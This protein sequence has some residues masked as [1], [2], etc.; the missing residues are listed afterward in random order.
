MPIETQK[1]GSFH[2]FLHN[3]ENN[4]VDNPKIPL[5]KLPCLLPSERV[6][7]AIAMDRLAEHQLDQESLVTHQLDQ[8]V[9]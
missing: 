9:Y 7:Q 4:L 3:L 5:D 1:M 2:H 6:Q 8:G